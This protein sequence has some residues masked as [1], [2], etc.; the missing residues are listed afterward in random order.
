MSYDFDRE[1]GRDGTFSTKYDGRE[2]TFNRPDVIPLWV[3][4]MD[5]AAPPA[6]TEALVKRAT[7]PVYGYTQFPDS[8]Y[9]SLIYWLK[10]RHG[11]QIAR[12]WIVFCPGVVP[13]LSAS[14]LALSKPDEAV[15]VQPPVYYPFFSVVK[16][17]GRKLLNNVLQQEQGSYGMD[18]ADLA[19]QAA[20]ARMLL[21]CSPHNP[22]GRVWSRSELEKLLDI[23]RQYNLI[24]VSDEIHADLIYPGNKHHILAD[25]ADSSEAIITAVAPSKTFNIPGLNLSALIIPDP[26]HRAAIRDQLEMIHISAANPFSIVAFEAAY[27]AGGEWLDALMAYLESSR[28]MVQHY[29]AEYLPQIRLI[30][31]QGTYLLWLDC[32]ELGMTDDELKQFFI[33]EAGI[34][35]NAGISYGREGSG[36]MRMNIGAPRHRIRQALNSI[37]SA[38]ERTKN[39][40]F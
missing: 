8:L 16:R 21:F 2:I 37:R 25:L 29:L 38:L 10:S 30:P 34:G 26:Q 3:A 31:S 11:W 7:H 9:E 18:F 20:S 39:N 32:R 40:S 27:R 14:V 4:D 12:E 6:V 35:L 36:F 1:I 5:F 13:S 22:V 28:E 15:I 23:T 33:F 24:V 19:R 17:T